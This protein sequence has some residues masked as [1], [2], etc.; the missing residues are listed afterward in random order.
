MVEKDSPEEE[1]EEDV[2]EEVEMDAEEE[3]TLQLSPTARKDFM[4][5]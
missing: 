2:A 5:C 4:Q 3:E 1:V